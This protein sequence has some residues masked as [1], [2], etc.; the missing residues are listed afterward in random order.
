MTTDLSN[1][2]LSVSGYNKNS[3]IL[4]NKDNSLS[5]F[6]LD[7]LINRYAHSLKSN[8]IERYERVPILLD[9]S[10]NFIVANLALWRCGAIPVSLNTRLLEEDIIEQLVFLES[11]FLITDKIL[12]SLPGKIRIL[13]PPTKDFNRHEMVNKEFPTTDDVALI[14]FTSGS[15]SIPKAVQLTF[16]NLI[17]SALTGNQLI[18]HQLDDKWLA[19]LPFYHIG[20]FSILT[21]SLIFKVPLILPDSIKSE[22]LAENIQTYK[23]T[24]I[25]LVAS[26]LSDLMKI[27]FDSSSIRNV[28]IGGGASSDNL[29]EEAISKGWKISKVYGSSET[30]AFVTGF[31]VN[32]KPGK[33]K[34]SG[35]ILPP[36]KIKILDENGNELN[37]NEQGEIAVKS[38][39]VMKGYF[40]NPEQTKK[41]LVDGYYLTGDYGYLDEDGFLFVLSRRSDIIV[42]GGENVDTSKV[43]S[44]IAVHPSV[45]EVF[46]LGI[47]D[48]HWGQIIAA[49]IVLK[50]NEKLSE[51]ELKKYLSD[52][53]SLYM[54]PKNI[55]FLDKIPKTQLGKVEREKIKS[56]FIHK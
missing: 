32:E 17:K 2:L 19:S 56:L 5:A 54:I 45:D 18:N 50:E 23:P 47:E 1:L 40:K 26:Q 35:K 36:N 28:L 39:S 14:I 4:I 52:K 24:L 7:L 25:S 12:K 41:V 38:D 6:E 33:I 3:P 43:E 44:V 10:I 34:S 42:T 55:L 22:S 8:S 46:I 30:S 21:R 13:P 16:D 15:T 31:L 51:Q 49:A 9:N 48:N 29:I 20:G 37:T 11:R 27:K 53:I